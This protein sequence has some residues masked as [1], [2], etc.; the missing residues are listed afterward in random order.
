MRAQDRSYMAT[1]DERH[2]IALSA[3]VRHVRDLPGL[4]EASAES[5]L[6]GGTLSASLRATAG[7]G[8][9]T[10]FMANSP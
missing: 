1:G 10:T 2:G 6:G 7:S 9:L 5:R 3:I 4:F 8:P